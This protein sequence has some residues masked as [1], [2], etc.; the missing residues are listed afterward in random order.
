ML[1][2]ANDTLIFRKPY[3]LNSIPN[4]LSEISYIS[5]IETIK[6]IRFTQLKKI[7]INDWAN[8]DLKFLINK[9]SLKLHSKTLES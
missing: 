6:W 1:P 3:T 7:H 2:F 5:Q 4:Y 9:N 8:R